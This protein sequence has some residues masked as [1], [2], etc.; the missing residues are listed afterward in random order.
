M[1]PGRQPE[2]TGS[3]PAGVHYKELK[4]EKPTTARAV[5]EGQDGCMGCMCC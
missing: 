4:Q 2:L 5:T 1:T 3:A